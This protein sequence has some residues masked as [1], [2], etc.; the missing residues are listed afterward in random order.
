MAGREKPP[1]AADADGLP[2]FDCKYSSNMNL[3]VSSS[4]F[5]IIAGSRRN[6]HKQAPLVLQRASATGP[7]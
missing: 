7:P 1:A 3:Q 5:E 6:Q 2:A 4:L